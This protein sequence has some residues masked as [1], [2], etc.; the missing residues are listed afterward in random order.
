MTFSFLLLAGLR[1][2]SEKSQSIPKAEDKIF[3]VDIET[4]VSR[5]LCA[6][7]KLLSWNQVFRTKKDCWNV[8]IR[9]FK[10]QQIWRCYKYY[11]PLRRITRACLLANAAS[12][13]KLRG[14]LNLACSCRSKT[15]QKFS[16]ATPQWQAMDIIYPSLGSAHLKTKIFPF[17]LLLSVFLETSM[18]LQLKRRVYYISG[19]HINSPKIFEKLQNIKL[20]ALPLSK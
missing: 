11:S 9:T 17:L 5:L 2:T 15:E 16:F 18:Q 4:I 12:A 20:P 19:F 1:S 7:M 3:L 14:I 6:L 8:W 10:T 13:W